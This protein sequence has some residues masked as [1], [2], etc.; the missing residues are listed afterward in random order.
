MAKTKLV[1]DE[2]IEEALEYLATSSET[3]AAAR[4]ARLRG[5]FERKRISERTKAVLERAKARGVVLGGARGAAGTSVGVEAA[6]AARSKKSAD[7]A[8]RLIEP[9]QQAQ[10]D[11]FVTLVQIA[12]RLNELGVTTPSG[13]GKWMATTVRRIKEK[14]NVG[15]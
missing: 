3:A 1:A 13:K 2:A 8:A 6:C 10:A 7:R 14:V 11:G 4:A 9:I 15:E 5:E 12:D